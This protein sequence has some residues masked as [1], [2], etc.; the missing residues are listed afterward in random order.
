VISRSVGL[1]DA[2]FDL[3]E[4]DLRFDFAGT[5]LVAMML[6]PLVDVEVVVD[7]VSAAM[8]NRLL[9][10]LDRYVSFPRFSGWQV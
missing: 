10:Y 2:G 8:K 4:M 5:V 3:V 7:E 9:P 6:A 1:V